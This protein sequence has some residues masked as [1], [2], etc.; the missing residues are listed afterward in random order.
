MPVKKFKPTTPSLRGTVLNDFSA[1]TRSTPEKSLVRGKH[2][3]GGRNNQGRTTTRFRG[4]GA[5]RSYRLIDF[6]RDKLGIPAEV[7]EIEY[8]PNRTAYIALL[9]YVDGEKRY[10]IAPQGLKQGD[11]VINGEESTFNLGDAL[12]LGSIPLGENIHNIELVPGRG[13]VVVRS[14][15]QSATLRS[16]DGD[17][18]QVKL[19]SGEVRLFHKKCYATLG[20]VSNSEHKNI[21]LGKAGRKRH[22]GR[23][24]HVRG[25]AMNPVDHPMG[26]GEGR[27]SG[28]GHP[29]SPWGWLTK[30]KKTRNKRKSSSKFIV[31]KR[32]K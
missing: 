28:G 5:K 23:R 15:G 25:V 1:I 6:K 21:K 22:L 30:G 16:K 31:E 2:R 10:I 13:G 14:A 29:R 27:T 8:D 3:T 4:G 11:K 18:V 20:I 7:A 9:H 26:G 19:P 17:Y 32:K 12:P 24:P